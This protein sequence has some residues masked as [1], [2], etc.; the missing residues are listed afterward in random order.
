MDTAKDNPALPGAQVLS[1]NGPDARWQV[2]LDLKDRTPAGLRS[3]QAIST[4]EKVHFT[5][6]GDGHMLAA[7][8]DLLLAGVWKRGTGLDVFTRVAGSGPHVWSRT[9]IPGQENC[10]RGTQVRAF[11]MHRDQ[12]TGADMVFAGV[13]N[14]IVISGVYNSR[15]HSI[16]WSAQPE[17]QGQFDNTTGGKVRVSGFATCNG[18]LYAAAYDAIY[19]RTDGNQP[20]WRKVY[21]TTIHAQSDRVTGFRGLTSIP[22][23][24]GTG[25]VLLVTVEDNPCRIYRIDPYM[26]DSAGMYRGNREINVSDFLTRELG[27]KATYAIVAYNDMTAYPGPGND[28][29]GLLMGLE[30]NTPKL[31]TSFYRHGPDAQYLIR[32]RE[33]R[34]ALR[35]ICDLQ[36]SPKPILVSVRTMIMSPFPSDPLGTVYAGGFDANGDPVHNTAWIYKGVPK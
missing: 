8:V 17:L 15:T 11:A 35:E 24:S 19:E 3:Y 31:S 33:G 21:V 27:T 12:V 6:D 7:P 32:D 23:P 1:L 28:C 4:L 22:D 25:E 16:E 26:T 20:T 9:Q 34:Y 13:T 18:K 2:D 10:P 30:V 5:T 14:A 29:V 36:I